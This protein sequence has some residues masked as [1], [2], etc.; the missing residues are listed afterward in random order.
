MLLCSWRGC[1]VW[2]LWRELQNIHPLRCLHFPFCLCQWDVHYP[3]LY[4]SPEVKRLFSFHLDTKTNLPLL[5]KDV[6]AKD[7]LHLSGRCV[8]YRDKAIAVAISTS[9][10]QIIGEYS[11]CLRSSLSFPFLFIAPT[12]SCGTQRLNAHV[13]PTG[14]FVMNFRF[15]CPFPVWSG[16]WQ[17]LH[18]PRHALWNGRAMPRV[19]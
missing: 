14:Y 19:Q 18:A 4:E 8:E 1:R 17:H 5:Q 10:P 7:F 2:I 12:V 3:C 16:D 11:C 15:P 6:L 9:I 13:Y